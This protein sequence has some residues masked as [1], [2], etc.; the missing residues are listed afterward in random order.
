[1]KCMACVF[2]EVHDRCE[3][4]CPECAAEGA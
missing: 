3:D 2:R 4:S 1:V